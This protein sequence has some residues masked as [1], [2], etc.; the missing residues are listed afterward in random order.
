MYLEAMFSQF[1][2]PP[3]PTKVISLWKWFEEENAVLP[4][5]GRKEEDK[6]RLKGLELVQKNFSAP[7]ATV[8]M[9]KKSEKKVKKPAAQAPNMLAAQPG[10]STHAGAYP[11]LK[12]AEGP[13]VIDFEDD[14]E[15]ASDSDDSDSE[16]EYVAPV[17]RLKSRKLKSNS[18]SGIRVSPRSTTLC[19]LH[20]M[21]SDAP[22][23]PLLSL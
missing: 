13:D 2:N 5:L 21:L 15:P 4:W 1:L 10:T 7:H 17:A 22:G 20:P 23:M 19:A 16:N 8:V 3:L 6:N 9:A 12:A 18:T 14:E 11:T